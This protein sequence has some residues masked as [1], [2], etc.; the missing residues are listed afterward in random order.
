MRNLRWKWIGYYTF[1][2]L[3]TAAL[4]LLVIWITSNILHTKL[5]ST[6]WELIV[7]ISFA[8]AVLLGIIIG[9]QFTKDLHQ[10]V[11]EIV[12]GV[13]TLAY[14]NLNYRLP[15]VEDR[16]LGEIASAFNEMADRIDAQVTSLQKL[17]EENE[18]LI[19]QAKVVAV[20]EERQRL[21][22][23]LHDAVSQ[24]LFAITLTSA[25]AARVID[26][27]LEKAKQLLQNIEHSANKAQGEMRALLLQLRPPMLQN[28]RLV[29]VIRS[30][31]NELSAKMPITCNL[32][33]PDLTLP[34]HIENQLYRILQEGLSNVLR[35]SEASEVNIKL[36]TLDH[37]QRVCL[38]IEDNGIG[39]DPTQIP[40]TSY[41][42]RTIKERV[43]EL[44]G[45]V[46]WISVPDKGT[47]LEVRIPIKH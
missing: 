28:Q 39:F 5:P 16:E 41:G 40:V 20:T 37:N 34:A 11:A 1:S 4:V 33:L 2:N 23:E 10:K 15:Y 47:R 19:Q 3:L 36:E 32:K 6:T 26:S 14:G 9:L 29:D 27:D 18:K 13:K 21:A 46:D 12:V 42:I 7:F 44:G 31:T 45:T 30:L 17:A 43:T 8:G 35:H 24:Q 38:I 25:T 22:Q